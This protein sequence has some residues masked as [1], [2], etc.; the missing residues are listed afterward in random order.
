MAAITVLRPGDPAG[1]F[2]QPSGAGPDGLLAVGGDLEPERL[3]A[4]YRQ[5]IFPWYEEEQPILWWSPDPRAV[6]DPGAVRVT[7][8]LRKTLRHGGYHVS[9]NANFAGVIEACARTRA[10]QGTWITGAMR[11]AYLRLHELGHAHSVESWLEGQL[12]GGLYGVA[13]GRVFF[14]E[15]MFSTSRDAS[16]VAFISLA[17]CLH[18]RGVELIDCQMPTPHLASLG[19]R[20]VAR[21]EFLRCLHRL[22]ELPD[23]GEPWHRAAFSTALL[24]A[25][26][27]AA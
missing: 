24:P 22:T 14:G 18:G 12:A 19:S 3:L 4:A 11:A 27:R 13:I 6:V 10:D 16:K 15:S 25:A 1:H 7:R 26:G 8:S 9:L 21:D 17:D 20:L 23:S 5:G 2:P